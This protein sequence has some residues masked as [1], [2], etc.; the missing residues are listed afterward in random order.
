MVRLYDSYNITSSTT[1][2]SFS[3]AFIWMVTRFHPQTQYV[4]P[5]CQRRFSCTPPHAHFVSWISLRARENLRY[6]AYKGVVFAAKSKKGWLLE[7]I[8]NCLRLYSLDF[9]ANIRSFLF[10]FF[11]LRVSTQSVVPEE[12]LFHSLR[13]LAANHARM[14]HILT[15][16]IVQD[17]WNATSVLIW[18]N[19]TVSQR[20]AVPHRTFNASVTQDFIFLKGLC[21]V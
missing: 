15:G 13:A 4:Q 12:H 21:S 14:A 19:T 9:L 2:K 18:E 10:C 20:L 5:G 6:H 11:F 17:V 7:K 3:V 8:Y 1:G 16:S